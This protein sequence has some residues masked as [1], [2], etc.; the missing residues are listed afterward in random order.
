MEGIDL[1]C[2]W[3]VRRSGTFGFI[4]RSWPAGITIDFGPFAMVDGAYFHD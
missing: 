4:G 1:N 3:N 2:P